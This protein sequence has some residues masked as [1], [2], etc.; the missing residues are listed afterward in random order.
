MCNAMRLGLLICAGLLSGCASD[1][2]DGQ[3]PLGAL[4]SV[5]SGTA[6]G[7]RRG[8]Q[9]IMPGHENDGVRVFNTRSGTVTCNTFGNVTNCN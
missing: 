1:E 5:L 9:P 3:S 6:E 4:G 7:L 2:A 8:Q